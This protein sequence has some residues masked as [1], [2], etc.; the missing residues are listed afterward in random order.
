MFK[1][2]SPG[3]VLFITTLASFFSTFAISSVN[4]ALPAIGRD[5][6]INA[7]SLNWVVSAYLL[8]MAVFLIPMGR[9]ADIFGRKRIFVIGILIF[10]IAG[11]MS[12]FSKSSEMLIFSR[13]LQG[14]GSAMLNS[15]S[16]AIIT[17]VYPGNKRGR[18]LGINVS[19]TYIGLSAG[20]FL[21]GIL[22]YYLGWRSI[23]WIGILFGIIVLPLIFLKLHGEW[24]ETGEE[25]IDIAGSLIYAASLGLLMLGFSRLPEFSGF[26]FAFAGIAGITAFIIMENKVKTPIFNVSLLLNNRAFA[27]SNLAAMINYS[28]TYSGS[29]FLSLYL[30]SVK[31]YSAQAAGL[32]MVT[33]PLIQALLSPVAGHLSDRIEPRILSSIGMSVTVLGLG[34]LVFLKADTSVSFVVLALLFLGLGFALFSSPNTNAVM[35]S[36]K[37]KHLGFASATL[38]TM[39]S[40]G[41]MASMACALLLTSLFMG[42][43]ALSPENAGLF[44]IAMKTGFIFFSILCFAGVFAS[45]ARGNVRRSEG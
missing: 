29:F 14:I 42:H 23:F 27:F 45:L 7:V 26:I 30:Q 11:V 19:A 8:T 34:A 17:A 4:V 18:A 31:G 32:I 10:M 37:K 38:S 35:S 40:V 41:Q 20:P 12:A 9:A 39:R 25:K 21:G 13:A 1:K 2:V 6:S 16:T 43:A 33:Q 3:M 22:T 24:R 28:A 15:T 5:F 36:I 44:L